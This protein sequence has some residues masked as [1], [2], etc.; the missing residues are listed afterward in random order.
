[1][2]KPVTYADRLSSGY[3]RDN[4]VDAVREI[5]GAEPDEW[6][7]DALEQFPHTRRLAMKAC[8]GPGK[9]QPCDTIIPTPQGLR[10]F[11][12]LV[13]GD[14]VFAGDGSVTKIKGVYERGILPVYRVTFDDKSSTLACGEHLWKVRGRAERVRKHAVPYQRKT[15]SGDIWS[16][17]TTEQIIDRGV[18]NRN[19]GSGRQFEIPRQGPAQ[20]P[21]ARL[22]IDP[23]FLG[24]WLGDGVRLKPAY[25][26]KP[27]PEISTELKC[28]GFRVS[29]PRA[30]LVTVYEQSE[31][32]RD[33]GVFEKYSFERFV[34]EAYKFADEESRRDVL[35]GLM[36]TDG[37][38][39]A[40]SHMEFG[41]TSRQLAEDVIWLARSLGG[42]AFMKDAVKQPFYY[43][44]AGAKIMGR[45]CY[46]VTLK[47]PFNPFRIKKRAKRWTD[48]MR[49]A[50]TRRYMTRMIDRI[51]P[52]GEADCRCIEVESADSLYL[53]NDFIVTHNT[54]V[55]AWI[56]WIFLLTRPHSMVGVTSI[57]GAN[58]KSAL[59]AEL[60]RWQARSPMLQALFTQTKTEIVANEAPKTWRMEARTWAADADADQIG[61]ALAGIHAAYV[62]WLLDESGDYPDAIMPVCE[63]IF[64]GNPKEAHIVQ[65]GN[66][67]RL[68]GPLYRA[69]T[70]ARHLW[71]VIEIT[72][73]PDNPKR[74]P[75]VSVE[76]AREQIAQYGRENPWVKVR[77]FGEFPDSDFN[78]LIGP[79]EVSAAMRRFYRTEDIGHAPLILGIDV[80]RYGDDQSVIMPRR[81]I[82]CFPMKKYRNINSTQ[83]SGIVARLHE[84][85]QIDGLFIDNAGLGGGGWI[86]ALLG[87]G[88]TPVGIDFGSNPHDK[89]RYKNKRAEMYFDAVEWIKR[90]G[91][92]PEDARLLEALTQTNFTFARD[93]GQMII[94][95]KESVKT[96]LNGHSP[97][98]ADAFV[99]TF[100]EPVTPKAA[101][102]AP[103]EVKYDP[104]RELD[105]AVQQPYDAARG[106]DPFRGS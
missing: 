4:M 11:G 93:S 29:E 37:G 94:E 47:L 35:C 17:L 42:V 60:A 45:L 67:T 14:E 22:R 96:K 66:P 71:K 39:D 78:A 32:L 88:K 70:V 72:A 12:D 97:D 65:A 62:M 19:D 105:K 104:F 55:L 83:G 7:K 43:G 49:S 30:G 8:A 73:D 15:Q 18:R 27:T 92:L 56:G 9:A 48:P 99:L 54:T 63:G 64:N 79:D 36:D 69:C 75:R 20:F 31:R 85:N 86:D 77:I 41:S 102:R 52:E 28:R 1:M 59:W 82:Q 5:F 58:L 21:R 53:T 24:V 74:T 10:R 84:D 44:A 76:V 23:Y 57:S 91:A 2:T 51:E 25:A 16:I 101:R 61:N 81:G 3:W 33:V 40:D 50:A 89:V 6:Q 98:E 90:G 100:A 26:T 95:P 38:I 13:A 87:L 34:P 68:G 103:A 106:Y 80:A 46:R